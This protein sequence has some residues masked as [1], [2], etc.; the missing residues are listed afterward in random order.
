MGCVFVHDFG[1][2]ASG[3]VGATGRECTRFLLVSP[4]G[5]ST[6]YNLGEG[7]AVTRPYNQGPD[8][9]RGDGLA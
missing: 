7:M 3:G 4:V 9:C 2:R 8:S 1:M 5:V 6:F